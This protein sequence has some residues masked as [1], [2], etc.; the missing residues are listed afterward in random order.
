MAKNSNRPNTD[1]EDAGE[2]GSEALKR[3]AIAEANTSSHIVQRLRN[4]FLTGLIIVGPVSITLYALWWFI[5]LVDAWV[6]PWVPQIYLPET[7][8]PFSVPGVGL[9]FS[10]TSLIVI[11]ALTANLFGRTIVSYGELMLDRMP[12]VRGIYRALKQ[13]FE[14]VLSQSSNSFQNVGLV[15][16]PRKGLYAIVFVSTKTKGEIDDKV[17]KGKEV[18]SVFL[19]TTPNP[20]SGYLLFVPQ[21]DVV[22]L[23]M[24]VEEGAK[25][26]IS[27]G[28]VVPAYQKKLRSLAGKA[29]PKSRGP[30][31]GTRQKTPA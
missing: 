8:L 22:I 11:G 28:L 12:V 17:F 5:N 21:E 26:V 30:A 29:K 23:D 2:T 24:S 4:Y 13:I 6:K 9:I 10:I 19:P 16:Y 18:L 25:L 20:T 15:E 1:D 31:R 27:A 3:L 14:T 7:Y